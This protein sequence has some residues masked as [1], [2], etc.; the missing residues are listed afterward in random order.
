MDNH[1]R[2]RLQESGFFFI[3]G[4]PS[5]E[6]NLFVYWRHVENKITWTSVEEEIDAPSETFDEVLSEDFKRLDLEG[7]V[8]FYSG[9]DYAIFDA[10]KELK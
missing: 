8:V 7:I 5:V 4:G 3:E 9:N 6:L 1:T 10:K 2:K